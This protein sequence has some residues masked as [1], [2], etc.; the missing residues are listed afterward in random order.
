MKP[1]SYHDLIEAFGGAGCAVCRLLERDA[2]RY[3]D[4]LLY[5]YAMDFEIHGDFRT[6]RGLCSI[7]SAQLMTFPTGATSIAALYGGVI[8]EALNTL[9]GLIESGGGKTSAERL[10]G[11]RLGRLLG[12]RNSAVGSAAAAAL[13]PDS[14]CACCASLTIRENDY[15]GLTADSLGDERFFAAFAASDGLCLLHL[16]QTLRRLDTDATR[17]LLE[18]Q[19]G[20]W[21]RLRADLNMFMAKQDPRFGALPDER[22]ATSWRRAVNAAAGAAGVFGLRG[23]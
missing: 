19:R 10:S 23:R 6:S 15:I 9:D 22:E 13:E 1:F 16:C 20:I 3:L 8:E 2:H 4:L 12:G 7:H 11:G 14:V 5:E 21:A 18:T 17:R